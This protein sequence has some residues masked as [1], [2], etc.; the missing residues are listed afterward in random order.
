MD[1]KDLNNAWLSP[2]GRLVFRDKQF[3]GGAAGWHNQLGLCILRD[4]WKLDHYLYAFKRVSKKFNHNA[5]DELEDLGWLRLHGFGGLTPVWVLPAK[6]KPT[7]K[8]A[9]TIQDWCLA[10]N[11]DYDSCFV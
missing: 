9:A 6:R 1:L 5:M 11:R 7:A 8:Q 3:D 4:L 2:T 10:N